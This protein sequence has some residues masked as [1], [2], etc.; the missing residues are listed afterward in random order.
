M[1]DY[2]AYFAHAR[3]LTRIYALPKTKPADVRKQPLQVS[4]VN[5]DCDPSATVR[6]SLEP[7][8][9]PETPHRRPLLLDLDFGGSPRTPR[10]LS[11]KSPFVG[12]P[13]K[14]KRFRSSMR[15]L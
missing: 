6:P 4:N 10:G 1:E 5:I 12:S 8:S 15:R 2:A 3:M 13:V 11:C 14:A 7:V 9:S